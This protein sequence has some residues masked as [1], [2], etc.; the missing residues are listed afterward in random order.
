MLLV[1]VSSFVTVRAINTS[2]SKQL[3]KQHVSKYVS[4]VLVKDSN[5]V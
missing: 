1:L 3:I 2:Q 5:S 4:L